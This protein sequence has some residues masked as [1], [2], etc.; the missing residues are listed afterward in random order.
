M[1][2]LE[3]LAGEWYEHQGYFVRRNVR[4]DKRSAGGWDGE[5]DLIAFNPEKAHLVHVECSMDARSWS[6]REEVYRR[7]FEAGGRH[8]PRLLVG[9]DLPDQIARIAL[10]GGSRSAG[11]RET[12]GGGKILMLRDFLSE[13]YEELP[14]DIFSAMVP[15]QYPVLRT[16][17]MTKWARS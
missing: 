2:W 11:P 3:Q 12:I 4:V 10:I 17:Q 15:E 1:N 14:G 9:F 8:I 13:I 6:K 16:I 7:K 5:L